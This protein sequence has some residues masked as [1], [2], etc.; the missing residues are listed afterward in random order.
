[1]PK[2][3]VTPA[4]GPSSHI[5]QHLSFIFLIEALHPDYQVQPINF[6]TTSAW[7][8]PTI[9][10][11][12]TSS[13]G[14]FWW[15]RG[16]RVTP[17]PPNDPVITSGLT[18]YRTATVF[19]Q[20]PST[21]HLLVVPFDARTRNVN[22]H[23]PGWPPISFYH[24]ELGSD[25]EEVREFYSSVSAVGPETHIAAPGQAFWMPQLLNTS[26]NYSAGHHSRPRRHAGLTGSLPIL[27]ALAIFSAPEINL[28]EAMSSLQPGAWRPHRHRYPSGCTFIH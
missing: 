23:R 2:P 26:Y 21:A 1:M 28:A 4:A 11:A 3:S 10:G 6:T 27:L 8:P 13:P 17:V 20:Y 9:R 15:W 16:G 18:T 5:P 14:T 12:Y 24:E 25:A 19:S 7:R 22:E